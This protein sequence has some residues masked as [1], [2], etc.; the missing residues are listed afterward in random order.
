MK[1]TNETTLERRALTLAVTV[2]VEHILSIE[3][4]MNAQQKSL[5]LCALCDE[6][7]F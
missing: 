3:I 4:A 5:L 7:F 2:T 6:R 1:P